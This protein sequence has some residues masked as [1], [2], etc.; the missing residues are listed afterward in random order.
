MASTG[1]GIQMTA[2][3]QEI[4]DREKVA[5]LM[6]RN[7]IATGHGDT[8]DDLL[9][10]LEGEIIS[11]QKYKMAYIDKEKAMEVLF[12]R[13]TKAGIDWSDLIS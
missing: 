13:L 1:S 6:L 12:D 8:I 4:I 2:E 10:E 3:E 9:R 11:L 7:S 5:S